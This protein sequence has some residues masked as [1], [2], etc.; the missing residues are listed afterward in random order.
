MANLSQSLKDYMSKSQSKEPLLAP[1]ESSGGSFGFGKWN[2][3]KK[4]APEYDNENDVANSWFSQAQK[5]PLCPGLVS[6]LESVLIVFSLKFRMF[7]CS[8]LYIQD[9]LIRTRFIS[10]F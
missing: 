8:F 10:S 3:F 1:E 9:L 6:S 2:P 4:S 7:I 5:D